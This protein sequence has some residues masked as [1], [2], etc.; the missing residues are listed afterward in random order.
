[1]AVPKAI[2]DELPRIKKD[3]SQ[4]Y[5][6]FKDNVAR[7]HMFRNYVFNTSI[8]DDQKS[9]LASRGQPVIEFN[10]QEAYVSR[11]LG[12]FAKH[13]PS[14]EVTPS[15]GIPVGHEIIELLQGQIRHII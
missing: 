8:N 14:I 2:Q 4:S 10:I 9:I 7:F 5:M 1:M 12:E 11:L 13:E 3:I 15:E 6:Y